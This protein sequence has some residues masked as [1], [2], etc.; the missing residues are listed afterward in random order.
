M[1]SVTRIFEIQA[2]EPY[3]ITC[4]FQD[5][6]SKTVDLKPFLEKNSRHKLIN[7]LLNERFFMQVTLDHL[8]G[9]LWP[10]GFDFSPL[11]AYQ[12]GQTT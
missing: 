6:T 11:S 1:K 3:K 5:K 2:V 8:G 12:M 10:N 9:L 4:L 7:P